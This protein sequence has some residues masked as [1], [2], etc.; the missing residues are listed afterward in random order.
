MPDDKKPGFN[1]D[2]IGNTLTV[3]IGVSLVCSV[4]VS[5]AA[6]VLR[7]QQEANAAQ[8]RQRIVLEVAGLYDPDVPVVEQF[9]NI[10]TRLVDLDTG[11]Y[12]DD[13][14]AES[15]DA[16]AAAN[17]P[18]LSVSIPKDA[19]IA[20]IGRRA[21]YAPVYVVLDGGEPQQYILP[22]RGKGLWSTLYG[23][24]SVEP[25][26][27]TVAGLRFY[28]HAETPGL[29]D[30]IE[31]EPWL[32]QWPGKKIYDEQGDPQI[33]V[34]RGSVQPGPDEIHQVDGLSGAT[35]TANGVTYLVQYWI[36]SHGFGPYLA[37]LSSEANDNG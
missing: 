23:Y 13:M 35:L 24:L 10:E 30:Q 17:D 22:V 9:G 1:R 33:K 7:P 25:D 12:V 15:F 4:L 19:D 34:V 29:G 27:E 2:S 8:F 28:E 36:G 16:E 26:G 3:A 21:V 5:A 37:R 14:D 11:E 32:S 6:I 31:K 18:K 20:K